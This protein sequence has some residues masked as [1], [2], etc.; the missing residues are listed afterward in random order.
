MK[1]KADLKKELQKRLKPGRY[2]HSVGVAETA[3]KLA[4]RFA[5]DED[6]AYLA[7]LLHDCAREF[8]NENMVAE[9]KKRNI[10]FSAIEEKMPI[11]LHAYI[12]AKLINEVYGID[13]EEIS[14]AIYAHTVGNKNMSKLDKIIYLADMIEPNRD[15]PEVVKLRKMAKEN[16]LDE[17]MLTALTESIIYVAQRNLLIHPMTIEARNELILANS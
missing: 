9:A 2:R 16:T 8:P 13:D 4:K 12:G 17:I 14:M 6:K 11:L 5:V 10:S 15:Y 3:V 7:G 1:N